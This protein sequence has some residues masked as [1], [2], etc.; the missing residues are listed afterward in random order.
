MAPDAPEATA[1]PAIEPNPSFTVEIGVDAAYKFEPLPAGQ[2][3]AEGAVV[4]E[5]ASG[6]CVRNLIDFSDCCHEDG[7][8]KGYTITTIGFGAGGITSIQQDRINAGLTSQSFTS[9]VAQ[10]I[11]DA[12]MR[13]HS[14]REQWLWVRCSSNPTLQ[15]A[16][17]AMFELTQDPPEEVVAA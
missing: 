9:I 13:D 10:H 1:A 4:V 16:L 14:P 6:T 12:A 11:Q 5:T 7:S 3:A 15:A 17:K 2:Q 8:H